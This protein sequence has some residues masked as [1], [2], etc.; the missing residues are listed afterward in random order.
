MSARRALVGC[1]VLALQDSCVFYPCCR[2]C[3]SRIDADLQDHNRFR[4]SR[5]GYRCVRDQV[6][7]RYRISLKVTRDSAIFGVTVFGNSLN[8]F[9]GIPAKGLQRLVDS[10][11]PTEQTLRSKLLV[12]AVEDCFIG[13]HFIFGIKLSGSGSGPLFQLP[14]SKGGRT[15]QFVASQMILPTARGLTGCTV[16]SYYQT[17]LQKASEDEAGSADP[18]KSSRLPGTTLQHIPGH[19]PTCSFSTSAPCGWSPLSQPLLRSAE[20]QDCSLSATPPWQ[21]S[22]G[23][24]TSSAETEGGGRTQDREHES[25]RHTDISATPPPAQRGCTD[26]HKVIE[27]GTSLLSFEP[28]FYTSPSFDRCPNSTEKLIGNGLG[29]NTWFGPAEPDRRRYSHK[30]KEISSEEHTRTLL[31]SS[32]AWD[33]LPF[34]ESLSEFL[35]EEK[36]DFDSVGQTKPNLTKQSQKRTSGTLL[37]V[38]NLAAESPSACQTN[39]SHSATSL[40][41]TNA[42]APVGD[43]CID[44]FNQVRDSRFK[45][46]RRS[47]AKNIYS[48]EFS[49]ED[50]K[51]YLSF[52]NKEEHLEEDMYDCSADLF[53]SSP[54]NNNTEMFNTPTE[55]QK[56][57][58]K[59]CS[60]FS[61]ADRQHLRNEHADATYFTPHKPN[62]KRKLYNYRRS[63]ITQE[64]PD[65]D[66]VPPSQSTPIVKVGV[67]TQS[68]ASSR[69]YFTGESMKENLA[70]SVK[71]NRC[72][73]RPTPDRRLRKTHLQVEHHLRLQRRTL[74]LASTRTTLYKCDSGVSDATVEQEDNEAVVAPTPL[75]YQ[76]DIT[77]R[78]LGS[79]WRACQGDGLYRK[80]PLLDQTLAS[81]RSLA[82]TGNTGSEGFTEGSLGRSN[83]S[84]LADENQTSDWSRDL[85]SDSI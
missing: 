27:E 63:L 62:L 11:Q 34:S 32:L 64:A 33:D 47:E 12:K 25:S 24:V 65:L 59:A 30:P 23:L 60:P 5:C 81:R 76:T 16:V 7:Y 6:G 44:L 31:S 57:K 78:D 29:V 21:Q 58:T 53:T 45:S 46:T 85:F 8:Q 70:W 9:F 50:D 22:L 75:S 35:C 73:N 36:T 17:L 19:S 66:F 52:E 84:H 41:V 69:R 79:S 18:S 54:T 3:C 13:R 71:P 80:G 74:D 55:T 43:G 61:K 28:S 82:W 37:E 14:V 1:S 38:K 40:G 77:N 20:H 56:T 39:S 48:C 26:N 67:A 49:Q 83:D 72:G 4:C 2:D 10:D 42:P 51:V 15:E 68:P